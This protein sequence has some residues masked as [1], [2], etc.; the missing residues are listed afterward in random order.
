[1]FNLRAW[2]L[3]NNLS[4]RYFKITLPTLSHNSSSKK[5]YYISTAH[6]PIHYCNFNKIVVAKGDSAATGHFFMMSDAAV[7]KD[8]K[9]ESG[10]K[11]TLPD[12]DVLESSHSAQLPINK[13]LPSTAKKT[14]ILP[15]LASSSLVSLPQLCDH[16]CEC[17][18]TKDSLHVIKE[19]NFILDPKNKGTQVL[20][21]VRNQNDRLWDIPI[22]Q[23]TRHVFNIKMGEETLMKLWYKMGS[24]A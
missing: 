14:T 11:V 5:L 9:Q 4:H 6:E 24:D 23:N 21:G 15:K 19:G 13:S 22:P 17:L 16:D 20:Y 1:M 8:I 12:D 7:L 2:L 3:F 10:I 18:L